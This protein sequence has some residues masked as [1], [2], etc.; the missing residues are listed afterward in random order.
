MILDVSK[1]LLHCFAS[2]PRLPIAIRLAL[3]DPFIITVKM[4]NFSGT[5]PRT[6]EL[7]TQ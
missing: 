1:R 2:Q 6:G 5:Q 7:L 4:S 3:H